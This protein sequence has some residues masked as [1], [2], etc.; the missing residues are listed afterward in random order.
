M[1]TVSANGADIPAIGLGTWAV[2]G[3]SGARI[4]AEAL[5]AGYRHIDTAASYGNEE[6]VGEGVRA[7][8]IPRD[9]IFVVTK[10]PRDSLAEGA[11]QRSIEGSLKRL[12]FDYVDLALIHWP[13]MRMPIADQIQPLCEIKRRGLARHI[14]VSNFSASLVGEAW[15]AASEPL[16]ANQCEYHPYLNQDRVLAVCGR[17]GMAFTAYCPLGRGIG[18]TEPAIAAPARAKGRTSAQIVLRWHLQ[19]P[20][21][22]AIPKSSDPMRLRENLDVFDF[23][24]SDAEMAAITALTMTHRERICDAG[25]PHSWDD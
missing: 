14:G 3:E 4:V 18:F 6:A 9:R 10:I 11:S 1:H 2:R 15:A 19:Q 20:G 12:R 17:L 21:V 22:V 5:A 25:P 13:N 8:G 16:A 24:L 7:S 23:A